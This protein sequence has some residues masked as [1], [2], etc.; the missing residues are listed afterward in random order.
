MAVIRFK[1]VASVFVMRLL[2]R[3]LTYD[4]VTLAFVVYAVA[5]YLLL[6]SLHSSIDVSVVYNAVI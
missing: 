3:K 1:I 5:A 4:I 6:V 2:A